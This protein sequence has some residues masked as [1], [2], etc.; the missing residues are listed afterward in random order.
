MN[1]T[2][3]TEAGA[4]RYYLDDFA[5]EIMPCDPTLDAWADWLSKPDPDWQRDEPATDGQQ[6]ACTVQREMPDIIATRTGSG[7]SFSRAVENDY[8]FLAVR[9]GEGLGWSPENII[10]GEDMMTALREWFAENDEFCDDVEFV[11]V[12]LNAPDVVATYRAFPNPHLTLGAL[13]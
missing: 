7:W 3:N 10:W 8:T 2:T 12:A 11:S 9:W 5:D 1:P 6:F 4:M 13:Q